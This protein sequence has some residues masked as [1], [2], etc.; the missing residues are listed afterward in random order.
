MKAK[1]A[2]DPTVRPV[3]SHLEP[4][5]DLLLA[6][7]NKLALPYRWGENRT[8]FYCILAQ[9]IDFPLVRASFDLPSHVRLEVET[10]SIQ[11]D[12]TWASMRGAMRH[13]S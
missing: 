7:G 3:Y 5:V 10:G 12:V 4:I 11:C 1:L 9:P 8:G 2:F 13:P 6:N